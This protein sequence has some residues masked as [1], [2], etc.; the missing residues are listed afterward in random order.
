MIKLKHLLSPNSSHC[1]IL[2]RLLELCHPTLHS[3]IKSVI[4]KNH[5]IN[6]PL[7]NLEAPKLKRNACQKFHTYKHVNLG[8]LRYSQLS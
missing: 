6:Y 5:N 1:V 3:K 2:K 8:N 4:E 7:P